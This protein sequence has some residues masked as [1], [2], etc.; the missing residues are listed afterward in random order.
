MHASTSMQL[1]PILARLSILC[2]MAEVTG[3]HPKR[4]IAAPGLFWREP[5]EDAKMAAQHGECAAHS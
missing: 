2:R 3:L 4:L 1:I 5:H